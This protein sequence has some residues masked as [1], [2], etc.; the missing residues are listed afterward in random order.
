MDEAVTSRNVVLII[1]LAFHDNDQDMNDQALTDCAI[2]LWYSAYLTASHIEVLHMIVR[3]L[4]VKTLAGYEKPE[5][6]D[7]G[8]MHKIVL[9][10]IILHVPPKVLKDTIKMLD[11]TLNKTSAE[12]SRRAIVFGRPD[13]NDRTYFRYREG[14]HRRCSIAYFK[15]TGILLP[16][17]A[18]TAGYDF[19]NP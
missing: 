14:L 19:P 10:K 12:L 16:L 18:S 3:P 6:T 15:E 7:Q 2:H 9:G 4:L 5:S 17:G 13:R 1:L 11:A 8:V